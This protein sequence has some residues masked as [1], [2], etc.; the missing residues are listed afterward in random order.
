MIGHL[1]IEPA[2]IAKASADPVRE[3]RCQA[4]TGKERSPV[5]IFQFVEFASNRSIGKPGMHAH[6]ALGEIV[7]EARIVALGEGSHGVAEPLDF[8]NRVLQYLV[9]EKAI[10]ISL[11]VASEK[12]IV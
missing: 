2:L 3:V 7:G 12:E 10:A 1:G 8:R 6:V 9:E 4:E 5:T 11:V